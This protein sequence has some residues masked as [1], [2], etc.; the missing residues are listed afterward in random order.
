MNMQ[1]MF[2]QPQHL[3]N[4]AIEFNL[5]PLRT[6]RFKQ[7]ANTFNYFVRAIA[8]MFHVR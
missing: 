1:V 8:V 3:P 6:G 2:N 5:N 7:P 4:K